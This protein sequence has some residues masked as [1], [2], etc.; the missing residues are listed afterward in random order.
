M[1]YDPTPDAYVEGT[2]KWYNK[3]TGLG[4]ATCQSF[5]EV[6]LHYTAIKN[7]A[8]LKKG[9]SIKFGVVKDKM[10]PVA[11]EVEKTDSPSEAEV[12]PGK[13]TKFD[14]EKKLGLIKGYDGNEVF[15]PFSALTEE[16]LN[17][18]SVGLDVLYE[19][20]SIVGLDDNAASQAI[21][22]RVRKKRQ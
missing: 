2:V 9:D 5:P 6:L 16:T 19:T 20:K 1:T 12:F 21:R 10:S 4:V 18:L 3:E 8:D 17:S 22:V 14:N 7:D 13:I 15:F 11:V